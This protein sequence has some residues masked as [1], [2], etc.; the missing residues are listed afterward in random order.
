MFEGEGR[1]ILISSGCGGC[2]R[3]GG[4]GGDRSAVVLVKDGHVKESEQMSTNRFKVTSKWKEA[5]R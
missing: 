3:C 2:Y 1:I 5:E 4:C